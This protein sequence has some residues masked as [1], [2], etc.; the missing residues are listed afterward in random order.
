MLEG[1]EQVE[2]S[3]LD[4]DEDDPACGF[5][6]NLHSHYKFP[7]EEPTMSGLKGK[8]LFLSNQL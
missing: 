6:Q 3:F 1:L 4:D 8:N 2:D 5:N 7:V